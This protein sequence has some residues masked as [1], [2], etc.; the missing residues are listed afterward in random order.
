MTSCGGAGFFDAPEVVYSIQ[1]HQN[2]HIG[3]TLTPM[4]WDAVILMLNVCSEGSDCFT[5]SDGL[6]VDGVEI[7]EWTAAMD[8]SAYVIIEGASG[9]ETGPYEI[10]IDYIP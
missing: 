10:G 8:F 4:G 1:L 3:I 2:D 6:G 9:G 5:Y 7:A